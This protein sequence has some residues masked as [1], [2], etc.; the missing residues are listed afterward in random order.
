MSLHRSPHNCDRLAPVLAA[1]RKKQNNC[2]SS[3]LTISNT[4]TTS[5]GAGGTISDG[6]TFGGDAISAGFD[7]NQPHFTPCC[8]A[9]RTIT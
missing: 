7:T 8:N 9:A 2:R 3:R 4:R 5:P 1:N 6:L